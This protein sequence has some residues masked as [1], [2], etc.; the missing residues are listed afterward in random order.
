MYKVPLLHSSA[1]KFS[2]VLWVN[3]ESIMSIDLQMCGITETRLTYNSSF[4]IYIQAVSVKLSAVKTRMQ[5]NIHKIF[6]RKSESK[7]AY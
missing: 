7:I 4:N 2:P 6:E 5:L 1:T 3:N